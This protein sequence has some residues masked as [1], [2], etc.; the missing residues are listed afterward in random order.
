MRTTQ[1]LVLSIFCL[2]AALFSVPAFA[3]YGA[4]Q[5]QGMTMSLQG[6]WLYPTG[7]L[8][9]IA[10][11][12]WGGTFSLGA[13]VS[14]NAVAKFMVSYHDFGVEKYTTLGDIDGGFVP[15]DLGFTAFLGY[16]GGIRPYLSG[17]GG[18][19]IA[20]G[21]FNDSNFGLGGGIGLDIPLG[22]PQMSL[23]I[24]PSYRLVFRDELDEYFLIN[25][26]LSFNLS[27]ASPVSR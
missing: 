26:G 27:A 21:D 1:Y 18:W 19:Y 7:N 22:S 24:E 25:V 4:P 23:Q 3:Q 11:D 8:D 13:N 17:Y 10:E 20:T 14:Q 9:D 6:A 12:G 2:T 5:I 16:P 15:L